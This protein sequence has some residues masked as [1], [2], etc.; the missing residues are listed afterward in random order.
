MVFLLLGPVLGVLTY[1]LMPGKA[2]CAPAAL[3]AGVAVWMGVWWLTEAVPLPVTSLLP[4]V[5]FPLLGVLEAKAV[6]ARYTNDVV[7]LFLGGFMV[8]LAMEKWNLHKRIA[9]LVVLAIGGGAKRTLF[10]FM[11]AT[12]VL[13][14]WISNTATAMMMIPI[15]MA[16]LHRY[17]QMVNPEAAGRLSVGLLLGIAYSASI[18]GV[19]TLVGTPP[20]LAF[21]QIFHQTFPEAPPVTFA[22]WMVF[23]APMTVIMLLL[24][25]G[26]LT[27]LYMRGVQSAGA[28]R[29][30]FQNELKKLGKPGFEEKVVLAVFILLAV[31]WI[32][33][34]P[35]TLGALTLPG[36]SELLPQPGFVGDGTVAITMGLLL[37][38]VPARSRKNPK[39]RVMDWETARKLPW[40]IVLLFGGGFALAAAIQASG[41]SLWIGEQLNG[42]A[43]LSPVA[44]TGSICTLMTFL[45]E[46]TSNT[47]TTQMA[48]PILAATA[49]AIGGNPL[50]LMVPA[51]LSASCAFM[52]P[53]ATPPNAIIFGTGRI[54]V[55]QMAKT[56]ILL[57]LAGVV[58]ITFWMTVIG[59]LLLHGTADTT[60]AWAL[61][62]T[63]PE[64]TGLEKLLNQ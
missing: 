49:V 30:V 17:E 24:T 60:P 27:F 52:M 8:A 26:L 42:L 57:N 46:L 39:A 25:W 16:V 2:V 40:G 37:F 47:A 59:P 15:A 36:W 58:V 51:T 5:F 10:G 7:F 12:A 54:R 56:G 44:M 14:M 20:N 38:L 3:T 19:G 34:K 18:G 6:A 4:L 28:T 29:A 50:F 63:P 1:L 31:L 9:L 23:A 11:V 62:D 48:L 35:L 33:R 45:T 43:A 21:A 32:T 22:E 61:P 64:Q 55:A 41:L 53:V 13:S